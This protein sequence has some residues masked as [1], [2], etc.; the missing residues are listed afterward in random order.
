MTALAIAEGESKGR[1]SSTAS[2]V[3][4]QRVDAK[5]ASLLDQKIS[6]L[7]DAG[8]VPWSQLLRSFVVEGGKR[9]RAVFCCLGYR[10]AGG[11]QS[12]SSVIAAAAALEL[13]QAFL[14]IQDDIMDRSE[15]RRGRPTLHRQFA[16]WKS[17]RGDLTSAD[18]YGQSIA[19]IVSNLCLGWAWEL[20]SESI[21]DPVRAVAVR[22]LFDRMLVEVNYGQGLEMLLMA[23]RRFSVTRGLTVAHYKTGTYT[24][25]GPL[26]VGAALAGASPELQ[27]AFS[28]FGTAA[29]QAFQLRDDLLGVFG[30]SDSTGKSNIDDLR[31]GKPTVL[32][33]LALEK[34][35]SVQAERLQALYGRADLD[36]AGAEEL[37][38]LIRASG[39]V[40]AV[41][42]MIE[43]KGRQAMAGLAQAP[44]AA[45]ARDDLAAL[46]SAALYRDR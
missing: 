36:S 25:V 17:Q 30:P 22:S 18:S 23:E 28:D 19:L 10:G 24:I 31:E 38:A 2:E 16:A 12:S 26:Q 35:S 43:E 9:M 11:E 41:E 14:L 20:V 3:I 42:Q 29:G 37:R 6:E 4:R 33:A 5:L 40:D 7:P 46:I 44:M 8:L 45:D 32:Y 15:L 39:A 27:Q 1:Q 34:S 13:F 21:S